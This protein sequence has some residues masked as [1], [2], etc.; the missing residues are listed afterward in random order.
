LLPVAEALS[1]QPTAQ[2]DNPSPVRA[3]A[4]KRSRDFV[5]SLLVR[6]AAI[7]KRSRGWRR[8]WKRNER[9]NARIS[10]RALQMVRLGSEFRLV[11]A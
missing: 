10:V 3:K 4:V 1:P 5:C 9:A 6:W 7:L 11:F 2:S 8:A